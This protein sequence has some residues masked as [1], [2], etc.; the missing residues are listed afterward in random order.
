MSESEIKRFMEDLQSDEALRTELSSQ[1]SG[2]GS[3]VEFAN[4]KG[5]DVTAEDVS[6]HMRA[7]LGEDLS[8]DELDSIAGGASAATAA[9]AVYA[10]IGPNSTANISSQSVEVA[11]VQAAVG[12]N[13]VA[14]ITA[15]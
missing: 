6:A 11:E 4:G 9:A 8:D 14:V 12:T 10:V 1:A 2:I 15:N 7:Q 5:Y 13:A 3:V